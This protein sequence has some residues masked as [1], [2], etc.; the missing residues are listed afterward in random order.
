MPREFI[1]LKKWHTEAGGGRRI[2]RYKAMAGTEAPSVRE[3]KEG[4]CELYPQR[5]LN[6]V[7]FSK[8]VSKLHATALSLF[9]PSA[10][11]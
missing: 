11:L 9:L 8:A 10:P 7:C 5:S 6:G 2:I 1:T 3:A 4:V